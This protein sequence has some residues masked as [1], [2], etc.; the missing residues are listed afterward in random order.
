MHN[1]KEEKEEEKE[2]PVPASPP[3]S[4]LKSPLI[5]FLT[6]TIVCIYRVH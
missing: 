2:E 3:A 4:I 1:K 6:N 5:L